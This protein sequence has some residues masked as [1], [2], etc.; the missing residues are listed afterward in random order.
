MKPKISLINSTPNPI[1]TMCFAHRVMH[2]AVPNSITELKQHPL[3]YLGM[4]INNYFNAMLKKDGMPTFLEYVSFVFKLDNV[5][6][7]LTHQLVRHRIGFSYSQQSL[8]CV[9]LPNFADNKAYHNP[10]KE[11]TLDAGE[12]HHYMVK[13]QERYR[14]A[15]KAG[16]ST[17][18]ARGLLP[19]NI[20]TTITFS[21]TLRALI[22]MV[23]KRLCK[24]TQQEFHSVALE[25]MEAVG[26]I[27]S[28]L[29]HWFKKPCVNGKCMMEAENSKQFD[30]GKIT[31]KQNTDH[32]CDIYLKKYTA[33]K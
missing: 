31:G 16:M 25:I 4:K 26:K 2:S 29:L 17:Q 22:G 18:D 1:E 3:M 9:D 11:G 21:C 33:L 23:N 24:K 27:D 15:L 30:E 6:R 32:C 14:A 19:I 7:A 10:Y 28:K 13:T 5:S 8:R 12:Y 20:Q